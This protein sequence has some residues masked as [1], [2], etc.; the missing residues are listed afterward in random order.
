[1]SEP[2]DGVW[3]LNVSQ[4]L[5]LVGHLPWLKLAIRASINEW[6]SYFDDDYLQNQS[7]LGDDAVDKLGVLAKIYNFVNKSKS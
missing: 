3:V 5:S 2:R 4:V 7:E 1:M 6:Q